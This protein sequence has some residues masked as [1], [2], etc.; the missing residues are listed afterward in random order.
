MH[1][2]NSLNVNSMDNYI[3]NYIYSL[4]RIIFFDKVIHFK[5]IEWK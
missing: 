4:Y 2:L 3:G 5:K 1:Q